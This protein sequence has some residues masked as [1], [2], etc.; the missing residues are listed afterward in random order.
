[1]LKFSGMMVIGFWIRGLGMG[2]T[3]TRTEVSISAAGP[4]GCAKGKVSV[5]ITMGINMRGIGEMI[6][7]KEPASAFIVMLTG[8]L[9]FG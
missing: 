8:I 2:L 1:M 9:G 4:A 3:I 6:R 5:I 7:K